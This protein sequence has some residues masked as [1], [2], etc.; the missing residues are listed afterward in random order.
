[1]YIYVVR[2]TYTYMHALICACLLICRHAPRQSHTWQ[3]RSC[4]HSKD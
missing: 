4:K 1:M 2:T 3:T